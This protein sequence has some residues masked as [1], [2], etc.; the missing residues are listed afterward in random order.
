V[1]A[2][3]VGIFDSSTFEQ[4]YTGARPVKASVKTTAK[5]MQH[6]IEDGS[7]ITDHRIIEPTEIELSTIL[8]VGDSASVY[9]NIRKGFI[10]ATLY[11]VQTK[12]GSY[13]N[14]IISAMPHEETA[15]MA[16]SISLAI[17]MTEVKLVKPTTTVV[18]KSPKKKS[19]TNTGKQQANET[20]DADK[21]KNGSVLSKVFK[22]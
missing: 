1:T 14:M 15:E 2:D 20:S 12:T 7:S 11:I 18:P 4:L 13:K 6:P 3:V 21:K 17:K 22:K 19:T 9:A 10:N 16:T 8:N 5:V